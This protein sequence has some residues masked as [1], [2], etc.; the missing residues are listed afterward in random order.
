[1]AERPSTQEPEAPSS[2]PHAA[3]PARGFLAELGD[4][5]RATKKWWLAPI[6]LA[7]VVAAAFIVLGGTAAAPLIYTLF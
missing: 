2:A 1:M 4:Y 3:G 5:L 7:L 6:V